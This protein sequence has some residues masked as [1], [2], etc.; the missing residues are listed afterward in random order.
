MS[1]ATTPS[2]FSPEVVDAR[3]A[4]GSLL[5]SEVHRISARRFVRM[6]LALALLAYVVI[7][8]TV[9]LTQFSRPTAALKAQAEQARAGVVQDQRMYRQQCLTD[10]NRPA[11]VTPEQACGAEPTV[12]DLPLDQFYPKQ[13]F[14]LA[15]DLP[16]G[17]VAVGAACAAL[18]FLVGATYVG[19]EWSSRSMVAL[20]FWEPRRLRVMGVKLVVASAAALVVGVVAQLLWLAAGEI[21]AHTRGTTGTPA[22]FWSDLLGLQGRV[23]LLVVLA[24][25]GGFAIANLVRNTGASLGVGFVYFAVVETAVRAARPAWQ[26][27]LVTDNAAALVLQGGLPVYVSGDQSFDE[28]GNLIDGGREMVLSNLHGGSYLGVVVL[29]LVVVGVVAFK[30]RDLQ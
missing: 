20:L 18:M 29:V 10:P 14:V 3:Y 26:Q 16:N 30:R 13:P 9:A 28:Q 6:L 17:A 11:D 7:V 1:T 27:W 24:A 21:I 5:R 12:S 25:L 22:G 15:Q 23:L 4:G 8:V 2:A 19:A